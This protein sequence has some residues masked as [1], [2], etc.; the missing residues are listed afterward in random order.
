MNFDPT[1]YRV[2]TP[3]E[4]GRVIPVGERTIL[5]DIQEGILDAETDGDKDHIGFTTKVVVDKS[6]FKKWLIERACGLD[7]DTFHSIKSFI[8]YCQKIGLKLADIYLKYRGLDTCARLNVLDY[9]LHTLKEN[10]DE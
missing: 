6:D 4:L 2:F 9:V 8:K 5:S 1:Q 10:D 7:L 3:R